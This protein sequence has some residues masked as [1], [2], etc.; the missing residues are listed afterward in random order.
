SSDLL[1]RHICDD[2]IG[3]KTTG[4]LCLDCHWD[5]CTVFRSKRDHLTSHI[6]VHLKLRPHA[7]TICGRTFKR[8]QD[9]NK[10]SRIH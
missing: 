9:L 6:R 10:H 8:M 2:H 4:N 1:Y 3:R 7:C 5:R